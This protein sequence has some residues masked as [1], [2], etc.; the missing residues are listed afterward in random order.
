[1]YWRGSGKQLAFM[2]YTGDIEIFPPQI[3]AG[4]GYKADKNSA[5]LLKFGLYNPTLD[6]QWRESADI[7]IVW[8]QYFTT[9]FQKFISQSD[10]EMIP[11]DM[12]PLA[13]CEDPLFVF[14]KNQ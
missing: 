9:E 3:H 4:G 12:G 6:K 14:G 11:Y 5:F 7:L 2:L 1:M 10:Y 8:D 13:Q